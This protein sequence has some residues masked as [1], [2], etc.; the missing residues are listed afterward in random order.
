MCVC[1]WSEHTPATDS[2]RA[3]TRLWWTEAL[4]VW[5]WPPDWCMDIITRDKNLPCTHP[6]SI[7]QMD[8][9]GTDTAAVQACNL[10]CCSASWS[11]KIFKRVGFIQL[12]GH[13]LTQ[14]FLMTNMLK[15]NKPLAVQLILYKLH[16]T[17]PG[18]CRV[19]RGAEQG[20][21]IYPHSHSYISMTII[22]TRVTYSSEWC[23]EPRTKTHNP[24]GFNYTF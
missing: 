4:L 11:K 9:K 19:S 6:H 16:P 13:E 8:F 3:D 15:E 22:Y 23:L 20:I 14:I 7:F 24:P 10:W 1:V 5:K 18:C 21:G 12:R 17:Y 2:S